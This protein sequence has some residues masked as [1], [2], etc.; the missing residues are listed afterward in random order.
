M[1]VSLS[2]LLD[3]LRK[4]PGLKSV[5]DRLPK[6]V[7]D[8]LDD[9]EFKG[10]VG[11]RIDGPLRVSRTTIDGVSTEPASGTVTYSGAFAFEPFDLDVVTVDFSF[12]CSLSLSIA[13]DFS[14]EELVLGV[15]GKF[16]QSSFVI[17]V[18]GS[19]V[20]SSEPFAG[21]DLEPRE[22]RLPLP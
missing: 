6:R 19:E 20:F 7:Q 14:S 12:D 22:L 4:I 1:S 18:G 13:L 11:G 9:A 8:A 10:E 3:K 16:G 17:T 21:V 5:L 15:S 2:K